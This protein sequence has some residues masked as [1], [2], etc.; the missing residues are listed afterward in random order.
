M[1]ELRRTNDLLNIKANTCHNDFNVVNEEKSRF[2]QE[3]SKLSQKITDLMN[4][5]ASYQVTPN[6][7]KK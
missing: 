3:N 4:E 7:P 6:N 2:V 1:E 5:E